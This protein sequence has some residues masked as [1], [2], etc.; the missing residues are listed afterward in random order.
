MGSAG[1]ELKGWSHR[2]E[3]WTWALV[4][5]ED[6]EGETLGEPLPGGRGAQSRLVAPCLRGAERDR[7]GLPPAPP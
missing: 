6:W 1:L 4:L 3:S 5:P 2:S 7:Q